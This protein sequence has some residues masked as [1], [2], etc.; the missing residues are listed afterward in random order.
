MIACWKPFGTV[1]L[2][3]LFGGTASKARL[4]SR[5]RLPPPLGLAAPFPVESAAAAVAVAPASIDPVLS[6]SAPAALPLSS[7]RRDSADSM[8]SPRYWLS[9]GLGTGL[10]QAKPQRYSQ[11]TW[12]RVPRRWINGSMTRF[13]GWL[14]LVNAGERARP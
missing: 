14:L 12:L 2:S 7:E 1:I 6:T 10:S 3:S 13:I 5:N 8:M 4:L 9:V 11:V